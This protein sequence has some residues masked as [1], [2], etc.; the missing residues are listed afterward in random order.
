MFGGGDAA[1]VTGGQGPEKCYLEVAAGNC[2]EQLQRWYFDNRTGLCQ[3]FTYTGCG[4][5]D[6][7][8]NSTAY[9]YH[10]CNASTGQYHIKYA[11][12]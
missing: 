6:N 9:C 7:N 5:N 4:G 10:A 12:L 8:F 2:S 3:P 11:Y 1:R